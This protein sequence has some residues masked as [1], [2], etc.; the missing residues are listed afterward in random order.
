AIALFGIFVGS[1]LVARRTNRQF[2][3]GLVLA[4]GLVVLVGIWMVVATQLAAG[5]VE[6]SRAEGTAKFDRLAKARILAQQAR[7]DETLQ[8]IARGDISKGEEAYRKHIEELETL[9]GTDPSSA[10]LAIDHWKQSHGKQVD[11]Y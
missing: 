10:K 7:T 5:A 6:A 3:M 2:N 8:L 11:F 4:A 1:V 9:L